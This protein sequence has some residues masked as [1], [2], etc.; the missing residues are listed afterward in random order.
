MRTSTGVELAFMLMNSFAT[1]ADTLSH[2][3]KY[4]LATQ[5]LPLEFQQNKASQPQ[6]HPQPQPQPQPSPSPSP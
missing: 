4:P 1:S 5:G 3:A 6:H 2:L